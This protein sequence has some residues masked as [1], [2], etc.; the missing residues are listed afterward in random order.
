MH[1]LWNLKIYVLKKIKI[2]IF[3]VFPHHFGLF[4]WHLDLAGTHPDLEW[5]RY[6]RVT[7]FNMIRNFFFFFFVFLLLFFCIPHLPHHDQTLSS[8]RPAYLYVHGSVCTTD[9][10]RVF[11]LIHTATTMTCQPELYIA[12]SMWSTPY[13]FILFK[14]KNIY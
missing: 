5:D 1:L 14:K 6:L 13:C 8:F 11:A 3:R 2:L 7:V 10:H 12:F 4:P 9:D